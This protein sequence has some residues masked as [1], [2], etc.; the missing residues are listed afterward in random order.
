[1][2]HAGEMGCLTCISRPLIFTFQH[3]SLKNFRT[4]P[5]TQTMNDKWSCSSQCSLIEGQI[6]YIVTAASIH[7]PSVNS[8]LQ[9]RRP[10]ANSQLS[11]VLL[12]V[13]ESVDI[14]IKVSQ[15]GRRE[16]VNIAK[17]FLSDRFCHFAGLTVV[18]DRHT[19]IARVQTIQDLQYLN[20]PGRQPAS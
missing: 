15:S 2:Q 12:A 5:S 3:S 1:M 14:H 4:R 6:H 11:Q 17:S 20:M 13:A 16:R 18:T 9:Y 7:C 8:W 10:T 19:H